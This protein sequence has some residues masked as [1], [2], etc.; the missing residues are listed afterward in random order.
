MVLEIYHALLKIK[1]SDI[2]KYSKNVSLFQTLLFKTHQKIKVLPFSSSAHQTILDNFGRTS[3]T[4]LDV[5]EPNYN[6]IIFIIT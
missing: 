1:Y 4:L 6:S 3:S 5:M 2:R